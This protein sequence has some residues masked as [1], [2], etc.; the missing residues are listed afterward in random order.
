MASKIERERREV[1]ETERE[2]G[3]RRAREGRILFVCELYMY[4][5]E[6]INT[7]CNVP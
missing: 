7:C 1:S 5:V 4:N 6:K 2:R 3:E